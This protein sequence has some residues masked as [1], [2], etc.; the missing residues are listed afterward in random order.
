MLAALLLS[1]S[2]CIIVTFLLFSL[3]HLTTV[4]PYMI[5]IALPIAQ[6]AL[7]MSVYMII[8]LSVERYVAVTKPHLQVNMILYSF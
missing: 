1:D 6:V 5:P 3:P 8:T 7:T 2:I 4:S